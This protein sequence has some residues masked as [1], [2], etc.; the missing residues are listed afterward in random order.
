MGRHGGPGR[1]SMRDL[2]E[3]YVSSATAD[4][5]KEEHDEP[6]PRQS[7]KVSTTE[8]CLVGRDGIP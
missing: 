3:Q 8:Q 1:L 4:G 2:I 5:A 6:S 7:L